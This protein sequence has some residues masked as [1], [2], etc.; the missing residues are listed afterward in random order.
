MKPLSLDLE[1]FGPYTKHTIDLAPFR[2]EPGD[3][4]LLVSTPVEQLLV[5]TESFHAGWQATT[6][7]R[8]V[9]VVRV[10]G[11]FLGVV[12]EPG[13]SSVQLVS[14]SERSRSGRW[15][16]TAT[17]TGVS[18]TAVA[19]R[20]SVEVTA[21]DVRD[22]ATNKHRNTDD[23]PYGGGAGMVMKVESLVGA[24]EAAKARLPDAKVIVMSPRGRTFTQERAKAMAASGSAI[25]VCGRYEGID[26]RALAFVD[27][28]LSL[29]DFV[30]TGGELAALCVIDAVARL[31]P[32]VLGNAESARIGNRV[33]VLQFD[34]VP[35]YVDDLSNAELLTTFL[36]LVAS[37]TSAKT[38]I[39]AIA[40]ATSARIRDEIDYASEAKTLAIFAE[41]YR[42]HP[43]IR[44]PDV[45]S[46][47]CGAR[48]L[49]MTYLDGI[50]W[51]E[52]Q[53]AEQELK[54]TWAEAI[55]RFAYGNRWLA[56]LLH[57][58]PHPSNYRFFPDGTV[59]FLDFGC[60]Q[61]LT[62]TERH[63]WYRMIR[64]A[65]EGRKADLRDAMS[66]LGFL[67]IDP[68]LSADELYDWWAQLL[69]DIIV[70]PQPVV[71]APGTRTRVLSSLFVQDP[72]HPVN[73]VSLSAAGAFTA[74]IQLNLVSICAAL[75][76]TLPIRAISEDMDGIS[77]PITDLGRQH[78]EWVRQRGLRLIPKL[79]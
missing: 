61:K 32:G 57:A 43:F 9:P 26:E 75:G 29:G 58:D 37:G 47:A 31:V 65:A 13:E 4:A 72:H 60:V 5:L 18:R 49:T 10:D 6:D 70:D 7:G 19:S 17:T 11:D 30:L 64:A 33:E 54:N 14:S 78:H 1:H 24:I 50:D 73:R 42:D 36:K 62:D 16:T 71:Y 63:S 46:E 76:A 22:F 69:S 2:D 74:R 77:E 41:L 25:L 15:A 53:H 67:D 27:E 20:L 66:Q 38:D 28:E 45:A 79:D 23:T 34:F 3:I 35:R 8:S 40:L 44:I 55:V 39:G 12:V 56:G 51:A 48:V 59:G 52:A 21:T 68:T